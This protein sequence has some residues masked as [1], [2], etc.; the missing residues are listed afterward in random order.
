MVYL[1]YSAT[2]PVNEE[3]LESFNKATRSYIGN[4]NSI[5]RLGI[6]AKE[7][8]DKATE[9]IAHILKVKESE[10]I[11]TS[12]AS[13]SNNLAIKGIAFKY[14]N[15]GKHIITTMLEHSSIIGPLS[16]LQGQGFKVDFVNILEN[17]QVDIDHLKS[18]IR[19]DTILVSIC[20]VDSEI[21][22]RQPVEKIGLL[23]K[24]YPKLFF[25]V[26][27]T[28]CLGKDNIDLT[29]IDL[30][31][32]SAQKIYGIKGIGGLIKKEKVM[33]EPLYMVVRV[34]RSLEAAHLL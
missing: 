12:G 2:T 26:D 9:Q 13:E 15:R 14:Q 1:D 11:Y 34:L 19:D 32:F 30:A 31:S 28:Q 20:A 5:H 7:M 25:H 8:I 22:L 33:L 27:M 10:V 16:Y 17:G 21:G 24:D 3:V 23:L 6:E 4:P 18:L 29:N